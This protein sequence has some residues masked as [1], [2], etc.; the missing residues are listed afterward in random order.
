MNVWRSA[1]RPLFVLA[2]LYD[3]TDTVFR[4]II[5]DCAPPDLFFTE[6]VNAD[7]LQSSG[8]DKLDFRLKFTDKDQPIIAQIWGKQPENFR[9]TA[10]ELVKMG[11]DGIDINFGC[12][13]KSV[14]KN[15][16]C[17][18]MVDDRPLAAEIIQATKKGAGELPVSV[19]TR[20]GLGNIDLTWLEFL[21][22]QK[23]DALIIHGRT[24][25]EMSK[26][27]A[28]WDEIGKVRAIRDKLAVKSL[29]IGNG[30]AENRQQGLELAKKYQLD[31]IMIGRG[32]FADPFALSENSPCETYTT[33][34]KINL[35]KKHVELFAKTWKNNERPIVTLNKFCKVYISGFDGA[36][37]LREEL[38]S[39]T[40]SGKLLE[41]LN[42][43]KQPS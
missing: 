33:E 30:D 32:V 29:I 41:Q 24:R 13:D 5:A 4:Q 16:C 10:A 14:V 8:R 21:L 43:I 19:K 27:P 36:K 38:M 11:Y 25:S 37:E 2:P 22:Q 9:K 28:H 15:G 40:S 18:A 17:I 35:Y 42:S 31:G 1:Q 26:V 20:L 23:L 3:V 12:P 6:F 7:G 39:A 34:Q